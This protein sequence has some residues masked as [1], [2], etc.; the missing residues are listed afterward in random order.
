MEHISIGANVIFYIGP[1]PITNTI[2]SAWITMAVLVAISLLASRRMNLVPKGLQNL[3][4]YVVELLLNVC[5]ST[6]GRRGR[7]F[8]PVVATAFLFILLANWIGLLPGYGDVP[9]LR[10]PDS[11][12]NVTAAMAIVVFFLVQGWAIKVQGPLRY[13]KEFL[14]PNPLHILSELSRPISLAFRLFGN[15]FAGEVVIATI[16][17][18]LPLAVPMVFFGFEIF[19]GVLQAII[20]SMLTLVFLTMATLHHGSENHP[21]APEAG[22]H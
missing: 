3:V 8:F 15:I 9:W 10:S 19:V 6:A 17:A 16:T 12:L 13:L 4:E 7:T 1:V 22:A 18:M 21:E 11:D 20:F 14:V 2:F 5:E